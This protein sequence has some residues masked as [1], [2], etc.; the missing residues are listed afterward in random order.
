MGDDLEFLEDDDMDFDGFDFAA[1]DAPRPNE[2]ANDTSALEYI[3]GKDMQGI[4]WERLNYSRDQ[5]RHLRLKEYRN[6]ESIPRSHEGLD[7][8]CQQVERIS[9][10]YDFRFNTRLV[11]STIVHFQVYVYS[12]LHS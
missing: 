8:E 3:N 7:M 10:F 4:P 2:Q 11:K 1:G 6:Y 5:Y 9:K 12:M